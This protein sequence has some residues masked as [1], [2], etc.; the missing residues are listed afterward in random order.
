MA[1]TSTWLSG[2]LKRPRSPPKIWRKNG[3]VSACPLATRPTLPPPSRFSYKSLP[4]TSVSCEYR[5]SYLR[6]ISLLRSVK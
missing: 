3:S 6:L 4:K 2:Y 5:S 1:Y